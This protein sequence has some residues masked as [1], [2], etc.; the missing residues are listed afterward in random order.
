MGV[1][2]GVGV[3]RESKS[4]CNTVQKHLRTRRPTGKGKAYNR[5]QPQ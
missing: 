5:Q 1:G 3:L 2:V 4:T